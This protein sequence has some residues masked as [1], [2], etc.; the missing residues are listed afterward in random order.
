[1]IKF[2]DLKQINS[3]YNADL[4]KAA[5]EVIDSGWYIRGSKSHELEKNLSKYLGSKFVIGVGNGL[6]AL[7]IILRSYK[8]LGKLQEGDEI[9]VPANTYIATVLAITEN[10]LTPIFVEPNYSDYNINTALIEE[11][12]SART[13]GILLV[14]LYG[15][16]CWSKKIETLKSKYN[17]IV[18]EDNA[19]AIGANWKG[20]MTGNLGDASG[21]SFYP[22]KNLG[23]LGDAGAIATNDEKLADVAKSIS[24]YGSEKKYFN[25]FQGLN[26][27]LDEIQA[28]FLLVKLNHLDKE[29]RHRESIANIYLKEIQNSKVRLPKLSSSGK[30]VWHLFVVRVENREDFQDYLFRSGI[31]TLIHYPIPI[32]KQDCY[33]TYRNLKLP[34]TEDIHRTVLS[35]PIGPTMSLEDAHYVA[36]IVNKY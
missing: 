17:L 21:L 28:A 24:N 14:H 3:L 12:I 27:R 9:I 22:G 7:S 30:H 4:K 8:E 19:Q 15:N 31:E 10:N 34:I 25:Q 16:P 20:I 18:I 23:A 6:D 29:N 1:M 32:H 2:L 13:K 11:R 35:L 5:E 33:Q 26:S 36:D